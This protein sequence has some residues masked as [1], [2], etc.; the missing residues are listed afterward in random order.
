MIA[1]DDIEDKGTGLQRNVCRTL[2]DHA[3]LCCDSDALVAGDV[4][5][6]QVVCSLLQHNVGR[7]RREEVEN[8]AGD[9]SNV[10]EP[11]CR[12]RTAGRSKDHQ[13]Q[14]RP[15]GGNDV[16]HR[17]KPAIAPVD[18]S[19]E[20]RIPY[21]LIRLEEREKEPAGQRGGRAVANPREE[22]VVGPRRRLC[23]FHVEVHADVILCRHKPI[24]QNR[25]RRGDLRHAAI[26][27]PAL[28]HL[29]HA[30]VGPGSDVCQQRV[31]VIAGVERV[32]AELGAAVRAEIV[33]YRVRQG[34]LHDIVEFVQSATQRLQ[35]VFNLGFG[36]VLWI[37]G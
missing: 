32:L 3:T 37:L 22:A 12:R 20:I 30:L 36:K 33:Q 6:S 16:A 23:I 28:L 9:G 17:T 24:G 11:G 31:L 8:A 15:G 1:A 18:A 10:G 14:S 29:C 35:S 4:A 13:S 25:S 19:F 34:L 7:C 2:I 21:F 26:E 5:A 27:R